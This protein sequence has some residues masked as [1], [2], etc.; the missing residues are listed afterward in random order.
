MEAARDYV[1]H[2]DVYLHGMYKYGAVHL[3]KKR[4]T[5]CVFTKNVHQPWPLALS[6]L[7]STCSCGL[8]RKRIMSSALQGAFVG[9]YAVPLLLA[10]GCFELLL[11][12]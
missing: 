9:L 6:L 4:E 3:R 7:D 10:S 11:R 8:A 1:D 12:A 2:D 5:M